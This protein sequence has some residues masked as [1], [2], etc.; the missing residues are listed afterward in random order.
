MDRIRPETEVDRTEAALSAHDLRLPLPRGDVEVSVAPMA[1]ESAVGQ[2]LVTVLVNELLR[3]KGVTGHLH[4][5]GCKS[6]S[7]D[8]TVPLRGDDL[9][10]GL[11]GL[12][13]SLNVDTSNHRA[14]I[15]FE[16][17]RDPVI[18]LRVGEAPGEG[19][20]VAADGWR[21]LI[22]AHAAGADWNAAPPF[23]AALA[24]ALSV[25]EVFK[26]LL[27]ANGVSN[28]QS[29]PI[30]DLAYSAFNYGVNDEAAR[31]PEIRHLHVEDLGIVGVGAGGS[32]AMYVLAMQ[33]GLSGQV[34]LVEPGHHKLSNLNR[35]LMTTASEVHE[36]M[37]KLATAAH[38][39]A[40]FAPS[41]RLTLV[42]EPWE[43][44][45]RPPWSI[46]LSTVDTVETRW[47]IQRRSSPGAHILD[48]AVLDMLYAIFR[49]TP[50]GRCLECVHPYDPALPG[51][52]LAAR[53]GQTIETIDDWTRRDVIVS[54][55]MIRQ[56]AITQN[57]TAESYADLERMR[58]TETR[59][60]IEECGST[61]LRADVPSQAPVLPIATTP[62]GVLLA[63]E[64]VKHF[65][66]PEAS[67]ANWLAHDMRRNPDRPKL[68]QRP[69][70]SGCP[71]HD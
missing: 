60:L 15:A 64:V 55:N 38:H 10:S 29:R 65:V 35:Y 36:A 34:F 56:L 53:W 45:G 26:A 30:G 33:P 11:A 63:G 67:L 21:A 16:A 23:G 24:A 1:A 61:K 4:V 51:K 20:I 54:S 71:H 19:M 66:A 2:R 59:G 22:G 9:A 17:C 5:L 37:H 62:V 40:T 52:Q 69:P 14:T 32:A 41:L 43:L 3:M 70:R 28:S 49:V 57:R 46:L 44:V 27:R 6:V 12:A 31:G 39:L 50:G 13:E 68:R 58:F 25:G 8:P 7:L 18:R 48:G 42:P 47:A